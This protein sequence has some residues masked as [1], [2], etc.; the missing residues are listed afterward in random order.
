VY[1]NGDVPYA[2][3]ATGRVNFIGVKVV[4]VLPEDLMAVMSCFFDLTIP[5]IQELPVAAPLNY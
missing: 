3:Y 2:A 5:I 4:G 1:A